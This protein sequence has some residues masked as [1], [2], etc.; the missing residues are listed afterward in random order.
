[1]K[2]TVKQLAAGT[3]VALILLVGN[4]NAEGTQAKASNRETIETT[5][6]LEKWMTDESIWN[7]NPISVIDVNTQLEPAMEIENWMTETETWNTENRLVNAPDNALELESWMTNE[8]I[9]NS[10]NIN[11]PSMKIESWMVDETI[12][13]R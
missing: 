3:L 8:N 11:E 6:Q 2:T 12:W 4:V 5:L 1:M 13:N 9:W 7:R 10:D